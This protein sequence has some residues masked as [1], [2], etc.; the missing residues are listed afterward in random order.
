M[1]YRVFF[2]PEVIPPAYEAGAGSMSALIAVLQGFLQN[3]TIC[4]VDGYLVDTRIGDAV[5]EI[6]EAAQ[7]SDSPLSHHITRLKKIL[8]Q[9]K[10]QNRFVD[11][12]STTEGDQSLPCLALVSAQSVGIDFILTEMELPNEP[13]LP[14]RKNLTDYVIGNFERERL[15]H[16]D[17][18]L[19]PTGE[20]AENEF[21][22]KRFGRVLPLAKKVI[23]ID[24]ILGRKFGDNFDYTI[25]RLIAY[26][27][28]T[29]QKFG[30]TLPRNSYRGQRARPSSRIPSSRLVREFHF[31]SPQ[32]S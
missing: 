7:E 29:N 16:L 2:D 20:D 17:D 30:A 5:R 27:E 12:L 28:A 19:I 11:I 32:I 31:Q 15:K 8:I 9:L 1:F 21:L 10:K 24:A 23:I 22:P 3:C 13:P 4:E 6:S 25:K 26:I 18:G 14:E